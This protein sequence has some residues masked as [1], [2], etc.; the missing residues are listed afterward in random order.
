MTNY[1]HATQSPDAWTR[2][3][4][5]YS[6]VY[7][8]AAR[9]RWMHLAELAVMKQR[10][11][12]ER[13]RP[14]SAV[15]AARDEAGAFLNSGDFAGGLAV[16][17]AES[18]L[19]GRDRAFGLGILHLRGLTLAGRLKEKAIAARHIEAA[20]RTADEFPEDIDEHG[21]HFGP[22]NTAMHAISTSSDMEQHRTALDTAEGL[23]RNGLTLPATRVGPLYMNLDRS[24][25]ALGDRDFALESLEE[26]WDV[27][28]EMARVH[29][30]SQELMR[31]LTSLHRRSNPM[32]KTTD[33]E[34][35]A[36]EF[37]YDADRRLTKI[38]TP[39]GRVTFFTYDSNNRVTSMKR[40]TGFNDSGE[41]GPTYTYAYTADAPG[42]AGVTT[43]TDPAGNQTKYTHTADGSVTKVTDALGR[44]RE[45][46]YDANLNLETATDAM[47]AGSDPANVT[48]YGWD[49][50]SNPSSLKLP[51]GATASLTGNLPAARKARAE[52]T[53]P[54]GT[55]YTYDDASQLTA[56]DGSTEGW[57]YDK[58]GNETAANPTADTAR[59]GGQWNDFSQLT[60]VTQGG[61]EYKGRYA[62]T[63]QSERTQFGDTAFHHGPVG[64]SA[65]TKAGVDTNL[66]REPSGNLHSFRT[67]GETYY[68]LTDA[69]GTVEAVAN[70]QGEKVN[71]YYYSPNG[72][73]DATEQVSQP[74]RFAGGYQD[75]TGLYHNKA[76]YL[77]P[78]IGRF[79]Q[80]DP[81]GLEA[82]PYLYASGDPTNMIDPNGLW[83]MPGWAKAAV[84]TVVTVA[85]GA[86]AIMAVGAAC[87]ATAGAACLLAGAVTG[88]LWTGAAGAGMAKA[89]G[90]SPVEGL[91][92]G[93]TGGLLGP[94]VPALRPIHYIN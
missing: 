26:A 93:I 84:G 53:C 90:Q 4:D 22:E 8:L 14:I 79:T 60:S 41:T 62:S 68:Y 69:L 11:A 38:T 28:P 40:A 29:P 24:Q 67:K 50:R 71:W 20:W 85:V 9:H 86:A 19:R 59:A 13:G 81:A 43:V 34:G 76:R 72:I 66:T 70:S 48:A 78:N 33:A 27:A 16:V 30:T 49:T 91:T 7:W 88:A 73:T 21:I 15:T 63:D 82:N 61:E 35:K 12:A 2:V 10:V 3:A 83:S 32:A 55:T 58:A 51:T 44:N 37:G 6:V 23:I 36:T 94:W 74:Y 65:Q 52:D 17:E 80:P 25:L 1:A 89:M 56:R 5:M 42:K 54:G 46:T 92:G 75:P 31:V 45:R 77:D 64:L 18:T 47:G 57:S 39:E 87:G